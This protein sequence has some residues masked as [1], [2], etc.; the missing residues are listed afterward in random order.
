MLGGALV[1]AAV[2]ALAA[3]FFAQESNQNANFAQQNADSAATSEAQ[4]IAEAGQRATAQ[5]EVEEA[6]ATADAAA[7][8]EAA[9]AATAQAEAVFR[10]T[11][12]GIAIEEREI[13]IEQANLARSRE[14]AV[15]ATNNLGVDPE[16]SILLALE[17]LA[18]ANT[19]EGQN[20]L[21]AAL[22][23]S[24]LRKRLIAHDGAI[25]DIA[26]S[27]DGSLIAMA[28]EDGTASIW[29]IQN[30]HKVLQW[31]SPIFV[32]KYTVGIREIPIGSCVAIRSDFD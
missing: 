4:A 10:A 32:R 27:S 11:A 31:V 14:L 8:A 22:F 26:Y 17:A 2:L 19:L 23:G 28:S 29:N 30:D 7:L 12:E 16:L 5:A 1:V 18:K 25:G 9:A 20:A 15:L 24:R 13:A 6:L 21:H 3:F